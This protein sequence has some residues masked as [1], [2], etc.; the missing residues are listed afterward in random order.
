MTLSELSDGSWTHLFQRPYDW[1]HGRV[2]K[3]KWQL[4][5]SFF[6]FLLFFFT[7][8][9]LPVRLPWGTARQHH[10]A[11]T[12]LPKVCGLSV[13][14]RETSTVISPPGLSSLEQLRLHILH[15][16]VPKV[17]LQAVFFQFTQPDSAPN[18][19]AAFIVSSCFSARGISLARSG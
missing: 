14:C 10:V 16:C 11:S 8:L 17:L 19:S 7:F 4:L 6:V 13:W 9:F 18:L 2:T 12:T 1:G 3:L 15:L 5:P